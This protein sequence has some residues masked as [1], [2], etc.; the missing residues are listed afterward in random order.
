MF[1]IMLSFG[2]PNSNILVVISFTSG[3]IDLLSTK[4]GYLLIIISYMYSH[5]LSAIVLLLV[6]KKIIEFYIFITII[7]IIGYELI[8]LYFI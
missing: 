7:L 6:Y 5:C 1:C 8:Y 4:C 2:K 3:F